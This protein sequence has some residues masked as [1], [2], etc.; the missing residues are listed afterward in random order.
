MV[1]L[2]NQIP[3]NPPF[4]KGGKDRFPKRV[5]PFEKGG[6]RGNVN[7]LRIVIPAKA[8][9][10]SL[11]L[12]L[13]GYFKHWTPAFAGVTSL[14]WLKLLALGVGGICWGRSL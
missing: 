5:P 7:N 8:G 11:K 13:N 3:P 1:D 12:R 6:G 10:Q 2:L 4:S 9:I 14:F